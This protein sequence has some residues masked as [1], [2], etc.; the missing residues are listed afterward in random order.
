MRNNP[1]VT[2]TTILD[3]LKW[4][5]ATKKFD[6]SR[7]IPADLWETLEQSLTLTP[8]SFGLQ[9]WQ[10]LVVE[11]PEIRKSLREASWGQAQLTDASHIIVFTARTTLDETHVGEWISRLSEIQSTPIDTLA[12]LRSVIEGFIRPMSLEARQAWNTRQLYI[13]LGQFMATAAYLGIDTCP[14]EGI[15]PKAYDRI[16]NLEGTGFA[17]A[18]GCAAGYRAADDRYATMP[19]ARFPRE[20]TIRHIR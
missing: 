11:N 3:A 6:P 14:L 17:T 7:T 19:K 10:F 5:Y 2:S 1:A 8:S 18:V 12:P 9:P 13:A 15:D 20:K 16:L 4:R